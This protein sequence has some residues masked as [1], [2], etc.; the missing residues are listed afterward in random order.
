MA[1]VIRLWFIINLCTL[2]HQQA[3]DLYKVICFGL[4]LSL[5]G[6]KLGNGS[7]KILFQKFF[8]KNYFCSQIKKCEQIL[9]KLQCKHRYITIWI[10]II[11]YSMIHMSQKR[12]QI[13]GKKIQISTVKELWKSALIYIIFLLDPRCKH[14][15]QL[16][17]R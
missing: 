11:T 13:H 6:T 16:D 1:Y 9:S 17:V 3:S 14:G 2:N 15:I 10:K 12:V 4:Q 7:N 8:P 5:W